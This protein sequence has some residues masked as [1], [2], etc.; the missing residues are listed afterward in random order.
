[1]PK[2]FL[3]SV[4][5]FLIFTS[6][7]Q[8][9]FASMTYYSLTGTFTSSNS[10]LKVSTGDTFKFVLGFD[11]SQDA[12]MAYPPPS[13]AYNL[14]DSPNHDRFYAEAYSDLIIEGSRSWDKHI[15][16]NSYATSYPGAYDYVSQITASVGERPDYFS[17]NF[18][19]DILL[20]AKCTF[21][22]SNVLVENWHNGEAFKGTPGSPL[23][24]F[25]TISNN[26]GSALFSAS[27]VEKSISNPAN[28]FLTNSNP[29]PIPGAIWL[30][31]PA[32]VGLL[33]VR[34]KIT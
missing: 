4:L 17:S 25:G 16:M 24:A 7:S 28:E 13:S 34:K 3:W 5:F 8:Q 6:F 31:G 29:T 32:F 1:M 33:G 22:D 23:Y 2:I 27:F 11:K 9:S 14:S 15:G 30:L 19:Y 10:G 26:L 20:T 12:W 18:S 21:D